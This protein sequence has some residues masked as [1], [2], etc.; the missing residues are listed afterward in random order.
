M[1]TNE[2][3]REMISRINSFEGAGKSFQAIVAHEF[4]PSVLPIDKVYI[5][6]STNENS[7][8][9]FEN[10]NKDCCRKT[11]VEIRADFICPTVMSISQTYT[12][13]ETVLDDLTIEY[14]GKMDTY[15]IGKADVD[16]DLKAL[17]LPCVITF[18]FEQC[19]AYNP[20]GSSIKPFADFYCK[21][22]VDDSIIHLTDE[23][24]K[25]I[26]APFV[27]GTYGGTGEEN[28]FIDL[29]FRPKFVVVFATGSAGIGKD[30][31][32]FNCY[33]A[34]ALRGKATK[35]IQITENGFKVTQSE[36]TVSKGVHPLLNY[37]GQT[38]N[39][40]AFK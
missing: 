20:E 30:G 23:E 18:V 11:R 28:Q 3:V 10:E 37:F 2:M 16:S 40:I 21:T 4:R 1:Q 39:Y 22:H 8:S 19:P 13:A 14:A 36:T 34:F 12:L 15:K 32:T 26:N 29:F 17:R 6:F 7:V 27:V 9:F 35:G 31:D 25:Y 33:F 24:K 5:S 38:Y